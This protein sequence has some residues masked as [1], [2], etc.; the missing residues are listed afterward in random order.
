MQHGTFDI[1][2][3][4][5]SMAAIIGLGPEIQVF[6]SALDFA[7]DAH[8]N[9]RRRSGD[10]Y[11]MHPCLAAQI[12]AAE[13]DIRSPEMLAAALL[14]DTIEDVKGVDSALLT[15]KFGPDVAA[16]VEGCTKVTNFTGGRQTFKKLVHRKI[17]SGAAARLEA[18]QTGRPPAQ[19]AHLKKHA[20][21]QAAENRR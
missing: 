4:R 9:Q 15:E 11:I 1:E 20:Q 7:C 16:I 12:L 2:D 17:F 8:K 14:H 18:G 19:H 10:P 21:R 5:Q 6:W 3:Y 13:L